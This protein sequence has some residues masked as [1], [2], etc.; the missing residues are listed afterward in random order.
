MPAKVKKLER[1]LDMNPH[2]LQL[3]EYLELLFHYPEH[4]L[5][6]AHHVFASEPRLYSGNQK[7]NHR[8]HKNYVVVRECLYSCNE[9]DDEV[10]EMYTKCAQKQMITWY[11]AAI[12]YHF[13]I[14]LMKVWQCTNVW[15][16]SAQVFT[17]RI[18]KPYSTAPCCNAIRRDNYHY[19]MVRTAV[20][21]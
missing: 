19:K 18:V 17:S 7:V 10:L 1:K 8:L 21:C 20:R 4:I 9:I 16:R 14:T 12:M 2:Y 15:Q 11:C 6:P 3:M 5:D 13:G